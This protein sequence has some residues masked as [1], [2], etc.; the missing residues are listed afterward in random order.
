MYC[1]SE[2]DDDEEGSEAEDDS[3]L[4]AEL[5]EIANED[6]EEAPPTTPPTATPTKPATITKMPV[7]SSQVRLHAFTTLFGGTI[8]TNTFAAYVQCVVLLEKEGL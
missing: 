5:Q 2:E 8:F 3:D 4:L 6:E 1:Q 7:Q